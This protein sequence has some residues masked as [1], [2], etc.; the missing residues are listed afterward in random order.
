MFITTASIVMWVDELEKLPY[1]TDLL[2]KCTKY[3]KQKSKAY[4][5]ISHIPVFSKIEAP[6]K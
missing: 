6:Q 2:A 1:I 4:L 5:I 3:N